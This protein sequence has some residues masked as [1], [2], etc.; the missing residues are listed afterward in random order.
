MTEEEEMDRPERI[1]KRA[2]A[3]LVV[4]IALGIG[5]LV[6]SGVYKLISL[7]FS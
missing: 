1:V 7:M 2:F 5:V 4:V 6:V 3:T